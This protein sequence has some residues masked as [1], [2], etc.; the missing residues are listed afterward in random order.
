MVARKIGK[1]YGGPW[2]NRYVDRLKFE[3]G[4]SEQFPGLIATNQRKGKKMWREY[5]LAITVPSYGTHHV[6]LNI[7]SNEHTYPSVKVDGPSESPHRYDDGSLCMWYP[8]DPIDM[9]WTFRDGLLQLLVLIQAHLFREAWWREK[10]E[11]LGP[12]ILHESTSPP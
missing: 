12:E 10:Q 7:F 2:Y 11:W 3:S 6:C 5:K 1:Y 4:V 9:R 8:W